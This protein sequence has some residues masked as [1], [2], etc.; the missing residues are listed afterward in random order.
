MV[1]PLWHVWTKNA[2]ISKEDSFNT[3]T[4]YSF[5]YSELRAFTLERQAYKG[6]R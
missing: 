6:T 2:G 3:P 5:L 4:F 1:Q